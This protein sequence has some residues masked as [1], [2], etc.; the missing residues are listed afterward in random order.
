MI[1][2]NIALAAE[3]N[4]TIDGEEEL[5]EPRYI[6]CPNGGKHLMKNKGRATV[7]TGSTL[8]NKGNIAFSGTLG[9]CD[10]GCGTYIVCESWP[11]GGRIP[12]YVASSGRL[13]GYKGGTIMLGG[14][15]GYYTSLTQDSWIQGF[16]FTTTPVP[17]KGI[18]EDNVPE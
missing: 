6:P 9:Q 10:N 13:Y 11:T 2:S 16:D 1:F 3:V 8:E 15:V 7:Y 4:N 18:I 12:G 5:I 14:A 17:K